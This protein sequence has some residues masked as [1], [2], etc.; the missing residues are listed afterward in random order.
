MAVAKLTSIESNCPV[1]SKKS[2]FFRL[3]FHCYLMAAIFWPPTA[4]VHV[5]RCYLSA[6]M[7]GHEFDCKLKHL[8]S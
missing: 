4:F 8:Q 6:I 7:G 5:N 2:C 1:V 3:C